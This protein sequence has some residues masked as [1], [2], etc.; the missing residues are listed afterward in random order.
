MLYFLKCHWTWFEF[1]YLYVPLVHSYGHS[2]R[3][4]T[5]IDASLIGH[6]CLISY[7]A[8][9]KEF[10]GDWVFCWKCLGRWKW[11]ND[12][13]IRLRFSELV[14][15]HAS[16]C[17]ILHCTPL[18]RVKHPELFG[19]RFIFNY[20]HINHITYM[21]IHALQFR[22]WVLQFFIWTCLYYVILFV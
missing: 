12:I 18:R 22:E 10:W 2:H 15:W 11:W 13:W 4:N 3:Y 8:W 17:S 20:S 7:I 5:S 16:F 14:C 1:S 9:L 21:L 19:G 6:Q